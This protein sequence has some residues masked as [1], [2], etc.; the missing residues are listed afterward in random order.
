MFPFDLYVGRYLCEYIADIPSDEKPSPFLR[1]AQR[2]PSARACAP[3]S[4]IPL[5]YG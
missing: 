2:D 3:S 5:E 1:Q 4:P